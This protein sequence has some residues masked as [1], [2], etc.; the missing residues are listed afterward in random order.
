MNSLH[1]KQRLLAECK[2]YVDARI[3]T[4]KQSMNDA[5]ESANEE[6]KSSVGDKYETGRAMMQIERDKA[7]TQLQE[8]LKL[9]HILDQIAIDTNSEKVIAG[10]LIVTA[11]KKIFISIGLGKLTLDGEQFLVVGAGSPLGK[12]LM[13]LGVDD[14]LVFNNERLTILQVI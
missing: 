4:A 3:A 13:G 9:K 1:L 8:A 12:A 2:R 11:S 6:S 10:S 5:Q 7:A 14:H